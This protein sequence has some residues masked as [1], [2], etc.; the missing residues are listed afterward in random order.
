MRGCFKWLFA[1]PSNPPRSSRLP[2]SLDKVGRYLFRPFYHYWG[3]CVPASAT[4]SA[5]T[6]TT[7]RRRLVHTT[8]VARDESNQ[9]DR[10]HSIVSRHLVCDMPIEAVLKTVCTALRCSCS[11]MLVTIYSHAIFRPYTQTSFA[12]VRR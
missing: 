1:I 6:S 2:T 10:T 9:T 5:S 8:P 3:W 12:S 4:T 7:F 11:A